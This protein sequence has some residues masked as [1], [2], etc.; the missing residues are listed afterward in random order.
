MLS[1][2]AIPKRKPEKDTQKINADIFIDDCNLGGIP[3]WG[4]IYNMIKNKKTW[5]DIYSETVETE[6]E[7][8]KRKRWFR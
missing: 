3:D 5:K 4:N 1:T 8:K 6:P 7:P 2:K